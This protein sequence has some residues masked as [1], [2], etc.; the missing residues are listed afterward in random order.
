MVDVVV[1]SEVICELLQVLVLGKP[2][3]LLISSV[4][5]Y[6]DALCVVLLCISEVCMLEVREEVAVVLDIA[7]SLVSELDT[8]AGVLKVSRPLV[9]AVGMSLEMLELS[10]VILGL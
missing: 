3:S 6:S 9:A 5:M 10:A 4:L 2:V 1:C 7:V 8:F